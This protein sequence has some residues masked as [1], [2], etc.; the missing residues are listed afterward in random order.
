MDETLI[1]STLNMEGEGENYAGNSSGA[2]FGPGSGSQPSGV[3]GGGDDDGENQPRRHRN[4]AH[5]HGQL[6]TEAVLS[7]KREQIRT[8]QETYL[9]STH[10]EGEAATAYKGVLRDTFNEGTRE[11]ANRTLEEETEMLRTYSDNCKNKIEEVYED[12]HDTVGHSRILTPREKQIKCQAIYEDL[13]R[14]R[15]NLDSLTD[16]QYKNLKEAYRASQ[17]GGD[18]SSD[19]S[20]SEY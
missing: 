11:E 12:M 13:K 5:I 18:L 2:V 10:A 1:G 14:K 20:D 8:I 7:E 6:N 19:S 15:E 4:G 9:E 3:Y 16:R 17:H